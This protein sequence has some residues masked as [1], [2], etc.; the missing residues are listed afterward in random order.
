M[1]NSIEL[2]SCVPE[3]TSLTLNILSQT[4][5]VLSEGIAESQ[6]LQIAQP[7]RLQF[8]LATKDRSKTPLLDYYRLSFQVDCHHLTR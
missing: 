4:G 2:Q 3:G 1:Q 7:V 8:V 5:E 6:E